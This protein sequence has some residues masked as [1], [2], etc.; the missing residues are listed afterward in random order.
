M[1]T[2]DATTRSNIDDGLFRKE[3]ERKLNEK[4]S[5]LPSEAKK[6]I[7]YTEF[8]V[9]LFIVTKDAGLLSACTKY[10][11]KDQCGIIV[12]V[13]MQFTG[14]GKDHIQI[15]S[16]IYMTYTIYDSRYLPICHD[17]TK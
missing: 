15:P 8:Y 5:K 6:E 2:L 3:I 4:I 11:V 17:N 10:T 1:I 7:T 16:T 14:Q 9:K 12:P 13:F